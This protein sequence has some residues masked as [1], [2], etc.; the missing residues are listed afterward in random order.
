LWA[1]GRPTCSKQDAALAERH[2]AAA[3]T[4][5]VGE[6]ELPGMRGG[7]TWQLRFGPLGPPGGPVTGAV[8]VC[9]DVAEQRAAE[10]AR[11]RADEAAQAAAQTAAMER[12]HRERLEFLV[13][14]HE[15]LGECEDRRAIMRAV[16][17][18]AVP[19]LGDWCAMSVFLDP[20]DPVPTVEVAHPDPALLAEAHR[21]YAAIPY[22]PDAPHGVPAVVRT[23]QPAIVAEM[24][25]AALSALGL[26]TEVRTAVRRLGLRSAVTVP[27][28]KRQ[29]VL[30]ALQFFVSGRP[31]RYGPDD[32]ALAQAVAG[33]VAAS[34]ENRRLAEH[35]RH[36]AA[37]LQRSLLPTDLPVVDGLEV[38]V[39][40]WA[41]GEAT[42][43]GGDFYDAF[44]LEGGRVGVVIGD[45]CGTG[46]AA[47]G[48]TAQA[49][50][51][52]RANAW[53]GDA[54]DVVLDRL[55]QAL[56]QTWPDTFC[57]A[58]FATVTPGPAGAGVELSLG[59]HP[60]PVVIRSDGTSELVGRPG[61]LLGLIEG[62]PRHLSGL[63]LQPGDALVFYTDGATDPPPP[64]GLG[65]EEL[66]KLVRQAATG[67]KTAEDLGDAFSDALGS[68]LP[69]PARHDD[70]ALLVLRV[71]PS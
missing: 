11:A 28:V 51:T 42:E 6:A 1:A 41:A 57:T 66:L 60:Q 46:P 19:R 36:I 71:P 16:T 5:E 58:A 10:D 3:L 50:Y 64:H 33:R 68:R 31:D 30:G 17:Q 47:A 34:L 61:G 52:V 38:A 45:V 21:L 4:G 7:A 49:R 23:G 25:D 20:L 8:V 9:R 56:V 26:P 35:Q 67:S 15:V 37:T 27:L 69:F 62:A 43:V 13:E 14:I 12:R 2:L 59:G 40:Y 29:H 39:R 48:V 32:V 65:D 70:V 54:P 63:A 18:A 24:D 55:H 53:R 44:T 22:D